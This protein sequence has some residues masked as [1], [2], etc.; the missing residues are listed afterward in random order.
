MLTPA[1]RTEIER[2]ARAALGE[3]ARI[4][5]LEEVAGGDIALALRASGPAGSIFVKLRPAADATMFAAEAEGLRAL[6]HCDAIRVPAPLAC[7]TATGSAFLILE[8]L[9]IGPLRDAAS[10]RRAGEALAALHRCTGEHFGWPTD[11]FIG[12]TPQRNEETDNWAR[13]FVQQRLQPQFELAARRGFKGEL[14]RNGERLCDK[15]AALFVDFRPQ[16]SLLHGDLW[17]GNLGALPDGSPV[18]F[19]PACYYGDREADLALSELFGGLPLDFYAAYR[20]AW[21]L[22]DDYET[23]KTLYNLYHILNHLNLF[24]SGYLRQAERMTAQLLASIAR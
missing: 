2:H 7:G 24:G 3:S 17:S 20:A 18:L 4:E 16:P 6:A 23:R 10:A 8:W 5:S 9:D 21:P 14:Q 15:A 19:D 12:S 1:L 13:F 11:N 22:A